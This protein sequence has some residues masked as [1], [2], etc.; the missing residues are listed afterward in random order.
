MFD[1]PEKS[2]LWAPFRTPVK[3]LWFSTHGTRHHVTKKMV[4]LD[5]DPSWL[6]VPGIFW[7]ALRG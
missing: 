5:A 3:P 7:S 4:D 6:K 1:R 2:V